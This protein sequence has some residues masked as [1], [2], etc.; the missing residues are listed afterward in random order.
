MPVIAKKLPLDIR[1]RVLT[2]IDY[3]EGETIHDRIKTVSLRTF[4]D[5]QTGLHYQFTWRTNSTWLYRYKKDGIT[6]LDQKIRSDKNT[7]RKVKVEQLAEAIHEVL[8]HLSQNKVGK[9]PK[10]ALYR[11]LLQKNYFSRQVQRQTTAKGNK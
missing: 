4:T 11:C 5:Q 1:L 2:A 10:S 7:Q 3:A 6:T 8:P 9:I